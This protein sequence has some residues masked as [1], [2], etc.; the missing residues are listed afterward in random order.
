[1]FGKVLG[2]I[3]VGVVTLITHGTVSTYLSGTRKILAGRAV[4]MVDPAAYHAAYCRG[5]GVAKPSLHLQTGRESA[6]LCRP[7]A[8]WRQAGAWTDICSV[9][10]YRHQLGR[11]WQMRFQCELQLSVRKVALPALEFTIFR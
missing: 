10:G 5:R 1:M 11:Y 4:L 7:V 9:A 3:V 6:L 2:C 8:K